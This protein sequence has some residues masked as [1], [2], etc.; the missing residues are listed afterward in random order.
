MVRKT[1]RKKGAEGG[2]AEEP[3]E[4]TP[5]RSVRLTR[6]YHFALSKYRSKLWEDGDTES[7]ISESDAIR[8]LL[9]EALTQLHDIPWP[10]EKDLR[11][12]KR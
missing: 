1:L 8:S 2:G 7:I 3:P 12:T 9:K 5:N 11:K 10:T 4:H 6:E